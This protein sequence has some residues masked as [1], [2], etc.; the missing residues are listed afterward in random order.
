MFLKRQNITLNRFL[1]NLLRSEFNFLAEQYKETTREDRNIL[2]K[3]LQFI[4]YREIRLRAVKNK[5]N[6]CCNNER[7][8]C[9]F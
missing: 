1:L 4:L 9:S 8:K 5:E 3:P 2:G 6:G 7:Y